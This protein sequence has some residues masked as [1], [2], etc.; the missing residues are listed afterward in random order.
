MSAPNGYLALVLHA[1]LPY[2]LSHGVWPHGTDWLN[3]AAAECYIPLINAFEDL[4]AEGLFVESVDVNVVNVEVYVTDKE[5][6][7]V[8]G[9]TRDDFVLEV[10]DRP[11]A[12]TNFY[13]VE[14]G[15]ATAGGVSGVLFSGTVAISTGLSQGC[16]LIGAKHRMEDGNRG[17]GIE[18]Y[19][20][21][22]HLGS[23]RPTFAGRR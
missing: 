6:N 12:I 9:L 8:T 20:R 3:E 15:R 2:V 4:A 7:R 22:S 19:L 16:S 21:F 11:V 5:G 1:H 18:K 17:R 13:A 14:D 10:S 23:L